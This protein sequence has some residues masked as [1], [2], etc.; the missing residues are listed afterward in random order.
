MNRSLLLAAAFAPVRKAVLWCL[1]SCVFTCVAA[2]GPLIAIDEQ[3]PQPAATIGTDKQLFVD[4]QIID[5]MTNVTRELGTVTKANGGQPIAF[6]RIGADGRRHVL[7]V[8]QLFHTV[9]YDPGRQLFR[10]WCRGIPADDAF[11]PDGTPDWDKVRYVYCESND[12]VNFLFQQELQGLY[13]RGDFNLVV[14]FDA[15]DADAGHRYRI[16]YDGGRPEFPNGACL[17]HSKDGIHWTPYHDGK[18]VTGRAADFSNQVY[19]DPDSGLFRLFTRTD[20]G[21][22]GGVDERR[23]VRMMTNPD[24]KR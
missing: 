12:G 18:P 3:L 5:R 8:W 14:T 2:P 1:F 9:Y 13:S 16:G 22:A 11:K 6:W 24:L 10:M 23:G 7:P 4:D 21:A 17:A 15:T 20:F 19:W